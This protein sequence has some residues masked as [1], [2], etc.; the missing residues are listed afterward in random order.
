M[1]PVQVSHVRVCAIPFFVVLNNIFSE[2]RDV[3]DERE[4]TV[5]STMLLCWYLV[6][7]TVVVW[8]RVVLFVS[9]SD[10]NHS[11]MFLSL[12]VWI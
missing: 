4:G 8:F 10:L 7:S 1:E 5:E 9:H 3:E 6:S 11:E 12:N 2:S